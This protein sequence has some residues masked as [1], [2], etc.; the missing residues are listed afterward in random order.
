[1]TKAKTPF[2]SMD[3]LVAY[4]N[5]NPRKVGK[6]ELARAFHIKGDDRL[7]LKDMLKELKHSGKTEKVAGKKLILADGL[8]ET[9]PCLITGTD[10]DGELIARP[11]NWTKQTPCPQILITDLGRLR[12]APR[13]GDMVMLKLTPKGKRFFHGAVV[14]RLSE[15]PNR[16]VGLFDT[17]SGKGGRILSVDR[18]LHQNYIVDRAHTGKAK[19]GDVVIAE[20]PQNI[21]GNSEK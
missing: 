6:R 9:C 21:F 18:R 12:P 1:M 11:L 15:K 19:N 10:S 8:P 14:R 17:T 2:P 3:D 13:E 16:V 7:K 5:D 4:L 20:V